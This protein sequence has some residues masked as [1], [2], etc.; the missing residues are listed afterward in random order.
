MVLLQGAD[1]KPPRRIVP[2]L[3][4]AVR[5]RNIGGSVLTRIAGAVIV[6]MLV[7]GCS[8][9]I[10]KKEI[11]GFSAGVNDLGSAY[12]SGLKSAASE[13]QERQRWKWITT[14]VPL[15]L[16]DGCVLQD[17]AGTNGSPACA[18]RELGQ[19]PPTPVQSETE[20]EATKAAP[21][22]K[23][24]RKYADAL[25]AVTNAE[26]QQTLEAAQAQ[27]SSSIQDLAKQRDTT[28]AKPIEAGAGILATVTTAWLNQ[29]RF[30]ILKNGVTAANE[31]V[32]QL[33]DAMGA[34]LAAIR[35]ARANELRLTAV[36]LTKGL[37]PAFGSADYMTRLNLIEGRVNSIDALRRSDPRQAAQEM[38]KAHNELTRALND[39]SRQVQAVVDSVR[40]F[41]DKAKAVREAFGG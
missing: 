29:R 27:F 3:P 22:I 10:Y 30:E 34:T 12:S 37:G 32:K 4:G 38:V 40:T 13:W 31:P 8:P 11:N 14:R 28:L 33:G 5:A 23:A 36:E 1:M 35:T 21:I 15:A 16:T 26:D 20:K 19:A 6:L 39:D 25:A 41:V 2:L 17:S 18:L 7:A 9:Y 24:L